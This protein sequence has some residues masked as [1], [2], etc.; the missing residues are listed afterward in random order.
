MVFIY[1]IIQ[2]LVTIS[3]C[4]VLFVKWFCKSVSR[5]MSI[6]R[7]ELNGESERLIYI[8]MEGKRLRENVVR[9]NERR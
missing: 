6:K 8:K 2:V 4:F 7:I 1:M 9:E 5:F 3:C